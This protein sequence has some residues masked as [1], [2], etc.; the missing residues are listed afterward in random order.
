MLAGMDNSDESG[1]KLVH[2]LDLPTSGALAVARGRLAAV[3]LTRAFHDRT[4]RKKYVAVLQGIPATPQGLINHP[5][6]ERNTDVVP[7]TDENEGRAKE[8]VTKYRVLKSGCHEE[9]LVSLV[10]FDILTGRKHQI[11]VH[12]RHN[13]NRQ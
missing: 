1:Y 10:E 11:R 5:L 8:A 3:K 9:V 4:V 13:R 2:R 6:V 12:S 7:A